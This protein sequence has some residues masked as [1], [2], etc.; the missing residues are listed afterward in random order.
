MKDPKSS[1]VPNI[2]IFIRLK[3]SEKE[4]YDDDGKWF[5]EYM[6]YIIPFSLYQLKD[7]DQLKMLYDIVNN[8]LTKFNEELKKYCNPMGTLKNEEIDQ[9]KPYNLIH[10]KINVLKGESI[11]RK[12]KFMISLFS[13]DD[14]KK[15]DDLFRQYIETYKVEPELEMIMEKAKME[16]QGKSPEEIKQY[17]EQA[18]ASILPDDYSIINFKTEAEILYNQILKYMYYKE[19]IKDKKVETLEDAIITDRCFAK[20]DWEFGKPKIKVLN[21]LFTGFHKSPEIERIE[22][23][24][25]AYTRRTITAVEV[26]EK[27]GD[28]L[29]DDEITKLGLYHSAGSMGDPRFNIFSQNGAA[30]PVR[31]NID[32]EFYR[33]VTP[34]ETRIDKLTGTHQGNSGTI[35][36]RLANLIFE[37]HFEFKAFKCVYFLTFPDEYNNQ[38]TECV[39]DE[40]EIPNT[41][42]KINYVNKYGQQSVKYEWVDELTQIPYVAEE[43]WIPRRYE[44]TRL[45]TD[46]YVKY[47][48]VQN[49]PLNIEN[50]YSDFELS[51]KG[52]IFNSRNAE[53]ISAVQRALPFLMLAFYIKHLI[54]K[55]LIKYKG[56]IQ[57]V[58]MD[59][60]PDALGQDLEGVQVRDKMEVWMQW[61]EKLGLNLYSGSSNTFGGGLAPNAT[62]NSHGTI[63]GTANEILNL[64]RLFDIVNLEVGMAMGISPQRESM[65]N[66]QLTATDNERNLAQS[67]TITEYYFD[68]LNE[69]W[70][71]VINEYLKMFRIY[72]NNEMENSNSSE[73]YLNYIL[74]NNTEEIIKITKDNLEH[75]NIG[76]Y[77]NNT[78]EDNT[79][80]EGML[81]MVHALA[82]NAGEGATAISNLL[83][84]ITS[85]LP[86]DEIHKEIE[87]LEEKTKQRQEQME[88]YKQDMQNKQI[89]MQIEAR[90]D[91][92]DHQKE[93]ATIKGEFGLREAMVKSFMNQKN[94]D[95]NA[96][97]EFDQLETLKEIEKMNLDRDYLNFEKKKH[98]DTVKLK[99]KEISAK[100]NT[101]K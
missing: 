51:Y 1:G 71:S 46:V 67:Y 88:K 63:L 38:I 91:E 7:F 48:E 84:S 52:L 82:Q 33:Q 73:F 77:L 62:P 26:I 37:T 98:E 49:Q 35:R 79:Y 81:Q 28:I 45:G 20:V 27:Y 78:G 23:G 96:N 12:D 58:N 56:F 69:F 30:V 3:V 34:G 94:Q 43:L 61:V 72:I 85:G 18:R 90:E 89:Q 42:T 76:L 47:G 53:S 22:H 100:K 41:A 4:K 59:N 93:L 97:G 14:L 60:I 66:S 83:K 54:N 39:S 24:D 11:K 44:V 101:K 15:K 32:E 17:E 55:E 70:K 2:P 6:R 19:N 92:Q 87:M 25:Y 5:K 64:Q 8:D 31:N 75:E 86:A 95:A 36:D 68:K 16:L 50:P 80:R 40:F 65:S 57:D 74:P 9:I 21:P 10:N 29:T 99:E 13:Q